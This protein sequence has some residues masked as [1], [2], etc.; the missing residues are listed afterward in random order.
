MPYYPQSNVVEQH[1]FQPA[2]WFVALEDTIAATEYFDG[3]GA[4]ETQ[5]FPPLGAR[6]VEN[7][8]MGAG[9][10]KNV[11]V[12]GHAEFIWVWNNSGGD[13]GFGTLVKRRAS[14]TVTNLDSGSVRT[15]VKAA[16]FTADK[17]IGG[18]LTVYDDAGAAG[19]APEAEYAAIWKNSVATLYFQPDLTTALAANDDLVIV[20]P[21]H[22]IAGAAGDEN[23]N[24]LGVIVASGGI[25]DGYLGWVCCKA[26]AVKVACIAAG[27]AITGENGIIAA[28]GGLVTTGAGGA[29]TLN[30]GY[31]LHTLQSDSVAR[32]AMCRIDMNTTRAATA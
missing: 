8:F 15:A 30:V 23:A 28:N 10:Y 16:T 24:L 3:T 17:E 6:R 21:Y 12:H 9:V 13:L 25:P 7:A 5:Q 11:K 14:Q 4:Y 26:D 2:Q 22:I 27:T 19:A 18:L 31:L 1:A 20:Y 32:Y 29:T